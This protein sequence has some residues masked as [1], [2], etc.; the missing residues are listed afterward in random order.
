MNLEMLKLIRQ[1]VTPARFSDIIWGKLPKL[2]LPSSIVD[3]NTG[4]LTSDNYALNVLVALLSIQRNETIR[5][6]I[7]PFI[8]DALDGRAVVKADRK[9]LMRIAKQN[10]ASEFPTSAQQLRTLTGLT[11]RAFKK[12]LEGLESRRLVW[13][14]SIAST[15][16]S[17]TIALRNPITQ[18]LLSE[19]Q[20][21]RNPRNDPRN[22]YE[23]GA[24][25][26][27]K[28]AD[29][30]MS[31]E[32]AEEL[33]LKL[34]NE[35]G[36]SAQREG[37]G[38]FK[39]CCPF[40]NDSNPSCNFNPTLGCFHCFSASCGEKGTSRRLLMQLSNE[41]GEETIKRIAQAMGKQIEFIEPDKEA[42]AIYEYV[43]KFGIV[44][45]QVLRLPDDENGNRRFTQRRRGKDGWVYSVKGM[46]PMLFNA[47]LL[48]YT[49]TVYLAGKVN[50]F[51]L[52]LLSGTLYAMQKTCKECGDKFELLPD[53]KGFANVC[54]TCTENADDNARKA[55]QEESLRKALKES[56]R[57]NNKRRE[58]ELK[59][60]RELA[61]LGFQRV[62]GKRFTVKVPNAKRK[63]LASLLEAL[64]GHLH[65][66]EGIPSPNRIR[67]NRKGVF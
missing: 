60:D 36:E 29:L 24:K 13:N 7:T 30:S 37:S 49:D 8:A 1:R 59:E 2:C 66:L 58:K 14:S 65:L 62:P 64:C 63:S 18:E 40:H 15:M 57:E 44:Q 34:L 4:Q 54:P 56:L 48:P 53:K 11:E 16:R 27:S 9:T 12:A 43:D 5:R 51:H 22:Y 28:R 21:E 61:A 50:G 42:L 67:W 3:K 17:L 19:S 41:S 33:F 10:R 31:P 52:K 45:K 25:G 46:R 23:E 35:R 26:R 20:F 32:E 55:A 47:R 38:E 6:T 39:F